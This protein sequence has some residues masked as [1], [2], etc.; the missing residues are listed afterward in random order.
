M[1]VGDV[2]EIRWVKLVGDEEL[3]RGGPWVVH[4]HR[5]LRLLK[6]GEEVDSLVNILDLLALDKKNVGWANLQFIL[7][8]KSLFHPYKMFS[9]VTATPLCLRSC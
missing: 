7:S 3:Q 2:V 4:I 9:P 1:V 6:G 8:P 5:R